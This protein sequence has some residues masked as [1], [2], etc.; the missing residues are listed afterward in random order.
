MKKWLTGGWP[1]RE[2]NSR[3]DYMII[4]KYARIVLFALKIKTNFD[5]ILYVGMF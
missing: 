3:L 2:K 5:K 1:P 4:S